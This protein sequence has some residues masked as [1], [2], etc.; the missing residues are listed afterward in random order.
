MDEL[1]KVKEFA[2]SF[3]GS[4]PPEDTV[5]VGR[6]KIVGTVFIYFRGLTT[7]TYYYGSDSGME[8]AKKMEETIKK[9]KHRCR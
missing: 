4:R 1:S 5:E 6:E 7:G 9:E 3:P 8:F 2:I